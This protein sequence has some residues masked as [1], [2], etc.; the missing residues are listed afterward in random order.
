MSNHTGFRVLSMNVLV[1]S[2]STLNVLIWGI[3]VLS[4][5]LSSNS[6]VVAC[7][8]SDGLNTSPDI[9]LLPYWSQG[10]GHG[11][12]EMHCVYLGACSV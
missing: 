4:R 12:Y 2:D 5:T 8:G 1:Q 3:V 7:T 6:A 9:L 10:F 11:L